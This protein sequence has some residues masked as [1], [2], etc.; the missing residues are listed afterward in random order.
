MKITT[1]TETMR[2]VTSSAMFF[3]KAQQRFRNKS[4]SLRILELNKTSSVTYVGTHVGVKIFKITAFTM[5]YITIAHHVFQ[6]K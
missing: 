6:T 5:F 1:N 4:A 2:K 3:K